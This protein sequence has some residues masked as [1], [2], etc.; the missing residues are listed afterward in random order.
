MDSNVLKR[1]IAGIKNIN[2]EQKELQ[3]KKYISAVYFHTLFLYTITQNRKFSIAQT[4]EHGEA[5]DKE[6]SEFLQ[7]IFDSYYTEFILNF[8]GQ[9]LVEAM[10]E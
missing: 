7:D 5:D 10:G 4:N 8:G 6:I 1:F 9:N 2:S 3:E